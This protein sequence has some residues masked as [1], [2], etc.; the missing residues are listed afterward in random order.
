MFHKYFI[1]YSPTFCFLSLKRRECWT[2]IS[3]NSVG[4][5]FLSF[6]QGRLN[7][8]SF[9]GMQLSYSFCFSSFGHCSEK[10]MGFW[11]QEDLGLNSGF[12]YRRYGPEQ[13][14]SFINK[15]VIFYTLRRSNKIFSI[16]YKKF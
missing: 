12:L 8:F 13:Y 2:H 6:S 3:H 10:N 5:S 15:M 1:L 9:S 14:I 11:N 7:Q 4:P 16:N